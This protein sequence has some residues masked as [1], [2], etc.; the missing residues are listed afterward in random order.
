VGVA[1]SISPIANNSN[2]LTYD[3]EIHVC[4]SNHIVAITKVI[5]GTKQQ[6]KICPGRFI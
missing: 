6:P 3:D 4:S 1:K 5:T 2:K